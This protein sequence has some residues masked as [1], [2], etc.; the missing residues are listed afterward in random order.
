[1]H[2]RLAPLRSVLCFRVGVCLCVCF[3]GSFF[4][5]A[6]GSGSIHGST[7]NELLM[8]WEDILKKALLNGSV[9]GAMRYATKV[10]LKQP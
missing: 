9:G 7:A 10:L 5:D 2:A 8:G 1:M 6:R 3:H 4:S